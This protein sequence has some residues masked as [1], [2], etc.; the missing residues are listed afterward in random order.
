MCLTSIIHR[1]I[2]TAG[3]NDESAHSSTRKAPEVT[4]RGFSIPFGQG[5]LVPRLATA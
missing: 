3:K 5:G 1:T 4:L 2:M